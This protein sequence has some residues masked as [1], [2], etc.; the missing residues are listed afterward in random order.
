MNQVASIR[1]VLS[2]A[3][4]WLLILLWQQIPAQVLTGSIGGRVT[5]GTGASLGDV[6]V[7][8]AGS[9]LIGGAT[10]IR[11]DG[12]G[13]YRFLE[14]PP[15]TYTVKFARAGFKI[16]AQEGIAINAGIQVTLDAKLELGDIAQE[17][18]VRALA[19]TI[20]TEHVT[21]QVVAG[22]T[23]M[24]GI[25]TGRAPWSISNTVAGRYSRYIRCRG[26]YQHA[27]GDPD[28]TRLEYLRPEVHDRRRE[29]NLAGRWRWLY[30]HVLR[31]GNVPGDQL[32]DR[33]P[34]GRRR[35]QAAFT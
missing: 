26:L 25:P 10:T 14:L 6:N 7:A 35:Q 31:H 33:R 21:S 5:D 4:A 30:R 1:R 18:T 24:E 29:R 8:A 27:G 20:D 23:V 9:A 22:Q 16:F 2:S 17:V 32:C 15:G 11:S 34:T 13:Y 19:A 28:G 3:I 12:N